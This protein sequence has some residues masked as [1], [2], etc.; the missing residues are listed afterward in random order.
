MKIKQTNLMNLIQEINKR[1]EDNKNEIVYFS[2]DEVLSLLKI[3]KTQVE[4][5][6]GINKFAELLSGQK[7]LVWHKIGCVHCCLDMIREFCFIA[8]G[9]YLGDSKYETTG[10]IM[11]I[12]PLDYSCTYDFDDN[13]FWVDLGFDSDDLL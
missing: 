6:G 1:I 2:I 4:Y 11:D 9:R 7:Q 8:Y 5:Y 10:T 12:E 13:D 3:S